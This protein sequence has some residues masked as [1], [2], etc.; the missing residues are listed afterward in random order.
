MV[1]NLRYYN[2]PDLH[3]L[4]EQ[5]RQGR[6]NIPLTWQVPLSHSLRNRSEIRFG[7]SGLK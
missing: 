3:S 4:M 2:I 5:T 1:T 6:E 7:T